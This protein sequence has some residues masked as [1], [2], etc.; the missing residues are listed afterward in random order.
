MASIIGTPG[1]DTLIG[2]NGADTIN[3]SQGGIDSVLGG[4]GDDTILAGGALTAADS[5]QGGAGYDK[6]DL[7]GD[8]SAGL[9]MGSRTL[10]GVEEIHFG[11]GY[12]YSIT[13]HDAAVTA[14]EMMKLDAHDMSAGKWLYFDGSAEQDGGFLFYDG[15]SNDTVLGGQGY[16][17]IIMTYGGVDAAFGNGGDDIISFGGALQATDRVDGGDGFDTLYIDGPN[18]A[19]GLTFS[20]TTVTNIENL[21]FGGSYNYVLKTHDGTIAAGENLF[22]DGRGLS[23]A[24]R[25]TFNASAETDGTISVIDGI[26]ND[27]VIGSQNGDTFMSGGGHDILS[28]QDGD[29]SFLMG[30]FLDAG[31]WVLGGAGYDWV[32]LNG[33]YSAGVTLGSLTLVGIEAM[34]LYDGFDYKLIFDNGNVAAGESMKIMAGLG[35]PHSFHFDGS[36]ESDGR[37]EVYGGAGDD[38]LIG[39]DGDD[40]LAAGAGVDSIDGGDGD[41]DIQFWGEFTAEDSVDGGEGNDRLFFSGDFSG[42]LT[43]GAKVQNIEGIILDGAFDYVITAQDALVKAGATLSV[44]SYY[45]DAAHHLRF[46]GTAEQDGS[47]D[48]TGGLG[49]DTLI[50]GAQGDSFHI[51]RAGHD[52]VQ[53][54]G[55]DDYIHVNA[56]FTADDRVDGGA[57]YDV[58]ELYGDFSAGLTLAADTL[59][60]VERMDLFWTDS[61]KVTTHD[62]TVAA[63]RTLTVDGHWLGADKTVVFDGS[64]ELDGKFVITSGAGKDV[65]TGG[66]GNDRFTGGLGQDVMTGG[67]GGDRF[68]FTDIADSAVGA[69]RD[70][71]MDFSSVQGDLVDLSAMDANSGVYGDQAFSF[72][73]NAAFSGVAGQLRYTLSNGN[74]ILAGDTNGDGAAEFQIGLT[75]TAGIGLGDLVL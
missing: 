45:L 25:M 19:G 65:L 55:G 18:Y 74:L 57:G 38:T 58:I 28:G 13:M 6:L 8:Y 37:F 29:D 1:N 61:Y 48:L 70:K 53:G 34:Q 67:L 41:D 39:G 21:A 75:N 4:A 69:A 23:G 54:R 22:V 33:D 7:A 46:N 15:F 27:I 30:A 42:G 71:I 14:G 9:A 66:A 36:A 47:F 3:M 72:I 11:G 50:G 12:N 5:I 73:G 17:N 51:N 2:T 43:L 24:G 44:D 31:D 32:A 20:A 16:D 64:A 60:N 40:L 56:E 26:N 63:G 59:V 10:R 62:N 52:V 68:I 49:D 35:A